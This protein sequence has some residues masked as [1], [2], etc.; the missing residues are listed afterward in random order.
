MKLQKILVLL[1]LT[2][3]L[4]TSL[5]AQDGKNLDQIQAEIKKRTESLNS[6][7]TDLAADSQSGAVTQEEYEKKKAEIEEEKQKISDLRK[8]VNAEGEA[9][10]KYNSGLGLMKQKR[11]TEAITELEEATKILPDFDKAYYLAGQCYSVLGDNDGALTNFQNT[12]THTTN[13]SIKAKAY[14]AIGN[15]YKKQESYAKAI[16]NYDSSI[17]AQANDNAYIGK[18][19]VYMSRGG[20]ANVNKAISSFEAALRVDPKS[21]TAAYNLGVANEIVKQFSKA[22]EAYKIA[23]KRGRYKADANVVLAKAYNA[24]GQYQNALNA[25]NQALKGKS[26]RK[27]ECYCELGEANR[28]LGKKSQAIQNFNSCAEDVVW[29]PVAEWGIK[30]TNDPSLEQN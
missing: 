14:N 27:A 8:I 11:Y 18:G 28:K 17:A 13:A 19:E 30:V 16:E 26:K 3:A 24:L 4:S 29:K 20:D 25:G 2:F 9:K 22:I 23:A 21:T 10:R 7:I 15:V 5:F 12:I 6:K 1:G